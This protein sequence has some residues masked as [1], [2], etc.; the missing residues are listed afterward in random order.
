[1]IAGGLSDGEIERQLNL[2][3]Q[4]DLDLAYS[5]RDAMWDSWR[6]WHEA[7]PPLGTPQAWIAWRQAW[8]N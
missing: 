1:V 8:R 2:E 7:Y 3:I 5:L 6:E 4:L